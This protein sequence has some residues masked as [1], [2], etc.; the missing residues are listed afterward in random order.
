MTNAIIRINPATG[1]QTTLNITES[2][3][4]DV[5]RICRLAADAFLASRFSTDRETRIA[6]LSAIADRL[7]AAADSIIETV[8]A[9]TA[10]TAAAVAG[11]LTRTTNQLRFFATVV[12]ETS[13]L[14]ATIDHS[15]A[16]TP[17]LRRMLLPTGPVAVFSASNFP[18]AF[19]VAGGDTA[20][21]L[22][23]GA[24]VVV[25]AHGSHPL[26][27]QLVADL[28]S[29]AVE[30]AGLPAGIFSIVYGLDAGVSLVR[31]P[32]ITAVG[33]TGSLAGATA[34]MDAMST[35]ATPIPFYGELGS[36][37]PFVITE[38][39]LRERAESVATDLAG[40]LLGRAGQLCTK[41]GI[42]LVPR[43]EAGDAFVSQLSALVD[44]APAQA[45]L[46][47]RIYSAYPEHDETS[48]AGFWVKPSLDIR[49]TV[50]VTTVEECFGPITLVT[51]YDGSVELLAAVADLPAS[52][53]FTIHSS[54][55]EEAGLVND[56]AI[57]ARRL[58]GRIVFNGVPTGVAVTWAQNHGGPWPSTN[59]AH[60]SVGATAIRRFLRPLAWQ[61]APEAVLP[62]ELRESTAGIIRRVDGTVRMPSD[63][64]ALRE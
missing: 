52:L 27:S 40:A 3:S 33:F 46:N 59:S 21:A 23:A 53:T 17:D 16:T 34:L 22:A 6:L 32:N 57:A 13:Y 18:L 1:S 14:E 15:T 35:R 44:G 5:A 25:K 29:E 62:V 61:N 4:D 47:E 31:D 19:S 43:G 42:V 48:S 58:A 26:S 49:D 60:T 37:N 2:T 28:I 38:G 24:P 11:E 10:L 30:Q 50:D 55:D 41:P 36:I 7:D 51:R 63:I 12:A 39:A 20:S 64:P 56:L 9:E 45:L 8:V 54:P